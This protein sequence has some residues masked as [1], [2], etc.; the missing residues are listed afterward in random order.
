[1][2]L[3]LCLALLSFPGFAQAEED[4]GR[5]MV[6][7]TEAELAS[8]NSKYAADKDANARLPS[9]SPCSTTKDKHGKSKESSC[10]VK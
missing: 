8:L 10:K 1:M 3:V 4:L 6:P 5:E 2:R 9:A 7:L